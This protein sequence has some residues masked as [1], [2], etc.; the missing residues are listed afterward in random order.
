MDLRELLKARDG[1]PTEA[2]AARK[3]ASFAVIPAATVGLLAGTQWVALADPIGRLLWVCTA[4]AS[5]AGFGAAFL[6][7]GVYYL[8]GFR[9][10]ALLADALVGAFLGVLYGGTLAMLLM[11]LKFV[12]L[13]YA[14][15][16]LLVIPLGAVAVPLFRAW[17]GNTP[18]RAARGQAAESPTAEPSAER[19]TTTRGSQS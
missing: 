11:S 8:F 2:Q 6:V 1:R 16:P 4:T 14:L 18:D 7:L 13:A 17:Q 12:P 5:A 19:T 3:I 15:C 9:P 10:V